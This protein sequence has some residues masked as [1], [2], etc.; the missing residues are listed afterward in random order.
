M[1]KR[2]STFFLH[3]AWRLSLIW[4]Q[5]HLSK[6]RLLLVF[7]ILVGLTAGVAA[8]ILKTLVHYIRQLLVTNHSLPF[9]YQIFLLFPL[10]GILLSML[11]IRLFFPGTFQRGIPGVLLA[12]SRGSAKLPRQSMFSHV[13]TS[14][15][16]VGLGGSAGLESPIV[17]TGSAIGSNFGKLPFFNYRD[18]TVLLACGAS[19]GIAAVFNAPV[20]GLLFSIEVLLAD[21]AISAFIPL[22]LASVTGVLCSKIILREEL[23][24]SFRNLQPFNYHYLFFYVLLGIL[25]GLVSIYYAQVTIK[26]DRM[27]HK[28]G[29]KPNFSR[30]F[31]GGSLLGML[32]FIFPPLFGEG[33]ESIKDLSQGNIHEL[34][35]DTLYDQLPH[36]EWFILA[37]IGAIALVK[38]VAT[39]VTLASGGNGGNFA[40]SLFVGAFVGFFFSRLVNMLSHYRLPEDNFTVVGMA[41]ILAGVMYAPLTGV[42]LIAEVT[43]GYDLIIPLMV[44]AAISHA[45]VRRYELF[46]M[47]TRELV[48]KGQIHTHNRDLN[49]LRS[50]SLVQLVEKNFHVLRPDTPLS[51]I[52]AVIAMTNRN[53]FPVVSATDQTLEG[54]IVLDD[55]KEV[56]FRNKLYEVLT[57]QKI[58]KAPPATVDWQEDM[59]AVMN[60]FDQTKAWHLPVLKAGKYEGFIS[61]TSIFSA[62]R[63]YLLLFSDQ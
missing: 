47:D 15:I 4:L 31:V 33:Y 58:M 41:G 13:L 22:I 6:T 16:T 61:K 34:F 54:V 28:L 52:V 62:Y 23:L 18:R 36:N 26:V 1:P 9:Q 63:Q 43:Q 32:I 11:L 55:I 44:V 38:V 21:V 24:F 8:V 10:L 42:F 39:S 57:A 48:R 53:I 29:A 60:K 59:P 12:I 35:R 46:P 50:L 51:E 45:L 14:G 3:K 27:F 37:L 49:I 40:P 30:V 17:A 7:S 20:A 5:R 25:S 2:V 56:M 19:A